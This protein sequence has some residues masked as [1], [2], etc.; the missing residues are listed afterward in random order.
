MK[1]VLLERVEKL[2]IVGDVL[3]V[4]DGFARN[5]LLPRNKALRATKENIELFESRK[6]QIMADNL[7]RKEEALKILEKL[8]DKEF[9]IVRS[10]GEKGHLYGSVSAADIAANVSENGFKLKKDQIILNGSFKETGV[11][12]VDVELHS[13]VICNIVLVI[14]RSVDEGKN[15]LEK[16][17]QDKIKAEKDAE[18]EVKELERKALRAAKKTAKKEALAEEVKV[19]DKKDSVAEVAEENNVVN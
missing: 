14:A 1:V 18:N 6:V 8:N 2:G 3:T 9:F 16:L 12:N 11:Y 10:A 19:E 5:F 13:E 17:K 7:Q 4:K 15:S